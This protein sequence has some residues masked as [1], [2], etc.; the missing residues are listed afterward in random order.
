MRR[1]INLWVGKRYR[2]KC[3]KDE[4]FKNKTTLDQFT[5]MFTLALSKAH[6]QGSGIVVYVTYQKIK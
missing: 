3:E 1:P 6:D 5:R 4:D 2:E